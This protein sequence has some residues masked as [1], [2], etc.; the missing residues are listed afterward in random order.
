MHFHIGEW[1]IENFIF[2]TEGVSVISYNCRNLPKNRKDLALRPDINILFDRCSILCLQEIWYTKQD[3]KQLNSLHNDFIG[4]G[5]TKY[6]ASEG[7][8]NVRGGV[9]IIYK[10]NIA[11]FI[12]I[13]KPL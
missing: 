11:N 9:A 12:N 7:L 4:I 5:T 1:D 3:L 2:I 6:D 10:K 8:C 13:L